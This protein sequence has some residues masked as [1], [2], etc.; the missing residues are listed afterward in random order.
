MHFFIPNVY[1]ICHENQLKE[2]KLIFELGTLPFFH[3]INFNVL[4]YN[5]SNQKS[6]IKL[7]ITQHFCFVLN[8][9]INIMEKGQG[10]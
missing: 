9:K 4:V 8:N 10:T 5:A 2:T 6:I 7:Y 3:N 1:L